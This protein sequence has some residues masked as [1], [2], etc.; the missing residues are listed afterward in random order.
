MNILYSNHA[1]KQMFSRS[2]TTDEVEYSLLN[3]ELQ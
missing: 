3:S 1:L 2:I